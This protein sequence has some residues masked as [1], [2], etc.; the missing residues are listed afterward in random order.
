MT[1]DQMEHV[2]RAAAAITNERDFVVIGSQSLLAARPDLPPPLNQSME[3]DLYPLS[4][5]AAADLIDGTI[6]E[7]SP[8]DEAF[9]YYAHGVGPE[10]AVLA[11]GW[12]QRA[13][14]VQNA[15]TGGARGLCLAPVD[16]AASKLAAGREKDL[17]FVAGMLALG[18]VGASDVRGVLPE[19]DATMESL[20]RERLERLLREQPSPQR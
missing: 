7:L 4:N 14:V 3:L 17:L 10:T 20:V 15:N 8:F 18:I 11:Q 9:G 16:L 13:I 2:L 19:L 5:P 12:Q 1:R 6:G